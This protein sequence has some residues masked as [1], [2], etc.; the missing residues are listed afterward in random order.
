M[1]WCINLCEMS[2]SDLFTQHEIVPDVLD[3]APKAV[4][5]VSYPSG[6]TL[7]TGS[8]LTPTQVKD[9]PTI[10]YDADEG[11]FYTLLLTDPDAPSR[12]VS[13]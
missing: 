6:V 4:L 11:S 7:Q 2:V 3:E 5:K 1:F 13:Q 8:E 10:E 9:M 12:A